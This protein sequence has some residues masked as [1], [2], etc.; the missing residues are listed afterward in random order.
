MSSESV[1]EV[2]HLTKVL[3]SASFS[4][5]S[6]IFPLLCSAEVSA[7]KEIADVQHSSSWLPYL[8]P[9]SKLALLVLLLRRT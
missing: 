3:I 4:V 8:V 9:V 5:P 7:V 6:L 2:P 1:M